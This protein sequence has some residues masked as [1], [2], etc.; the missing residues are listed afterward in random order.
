MEVSMKKGPGRPRKDEE[1]YQKPYDD[2]FKR[3]AVE[4]LVQTRKPLRQLARELGVSDTSLREWKED[5]L[6][7]HSGELK[8]DGEKRWNRLKVEAENSRL[9]EEVDKLKRQR[10]IL[11]KAL[12]ILSDPPPGSML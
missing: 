5:L 7:P 3:N 1:G 10:D 6:N 9:R 12:S 11:K 2:E 4:L 8:N